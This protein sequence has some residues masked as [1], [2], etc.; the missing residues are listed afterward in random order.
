MW[1]GDASHQGACVWGDRGPVVF[2]TGRYAVEF[3]DRR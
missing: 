1:R 3:Q 2:E